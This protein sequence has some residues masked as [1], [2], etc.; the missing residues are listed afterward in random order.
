MTL[1]DGLDLLAEFMG[2]GDAVASVTSA[3]MD[4]TMNLE[5]A[6]QARL[7]LIA[8]SPSDIKRFLKAH[9]PGTR[10]VQVRVWCVCVF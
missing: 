4:G 1:N 7:D 8:C 2:V 3:A 9:P 6:L 10:L 5:Q